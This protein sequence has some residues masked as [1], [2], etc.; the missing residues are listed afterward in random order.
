ML[1]C[2]AV[3]CSVLQRVA[4]YD[5]VSR[6]LNPLTHTDTHTPTSHTYTHTEFRSKSPLR[7]SHSLSVSLQYIDT[8][9]LTACAYTHTKIARKSPVPFFLFL[10]GFLTYMYPHT[11][12]PRTST[13][14]GLRKKLF[15]CLVSLSFGLLQ[16]Y[17]LMPRMDKC[18]CKR[19]CVCVFCV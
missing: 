6:R 18:V 9:T 11:T 8:Y 2:I 12:M 1:Q 7:F 19:L 13:Q 5:S 14:T 3:Y 15:C 17:T 16:R 10:L 4:A